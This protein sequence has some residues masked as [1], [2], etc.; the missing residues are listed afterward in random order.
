MDRTPSKG[1]NVYAGVYN[2]PYVLGG[3]LNLVLE[4]PLGKVANATKPGYIH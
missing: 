2:T 3:T 4:R 1:C